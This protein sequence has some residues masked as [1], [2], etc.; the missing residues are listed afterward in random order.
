M[1][2][3]DEAEFWKFIEAK[4]G[5]PWHIRQGL[6]AQ[7]G[8]AISQSIREVNYQL[9]I[10]DKT[11][12]KIVNLLQTPFGKMIFLYLASTDEHFKT[13]LKEK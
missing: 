11:S 9:S 4:D 7:Y 1:K 5:V 10:M 3:I 13:F 12:Q 2:L 8:T 6:K